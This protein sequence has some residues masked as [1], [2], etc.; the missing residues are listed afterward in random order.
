MVTVPIPSPGVPLAFG[1]PG[2]PLVIVLHDAFGRLPW[3]EPYAAAL[4]DRGGFRVLVPDL[5][6]GVAT[7]DDDD[8]ER[9]AAGLGREAALASVAALIGA[10]RAEG[11]PRIG[12][13]G[14]AFGGTLALE[15]AQE[16]SADAVV[17]Y[18]AT[19]APSGGIIPTPVLLHLAESDDRVPA[20]DVAAF[21][22]SLHGDGTPVAR[23]TYAGTGHLFA[24]ASRRDLVDTRA[25]ALAFARTTVFLE[26]HLAD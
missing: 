25:A 3:L 4:A 8:A 11:S 21:I 14:F 12:L 2:A 6:D 1:D 23:H 9:L 17:A 18:Y 22:D 19:A 10:A 7:V 15:A 13:V 5:F 16:G 24:N 20:A 26:A